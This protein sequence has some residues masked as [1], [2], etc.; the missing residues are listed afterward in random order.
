MGIHDDPTRQDTWNIGVNIEDAQGVMQSWGLW[1]KKTGGELDSDST[2]Y[3]PGGM[4]AQIDLGGRKTAGN[5]TLQKLYDI[6]YDHERIGQLLERVGRAKVNVHQ[7]P[8][9]IDGNPAVKA[10]NWNGRLK[11]VSLPDVDSE[12]STAALVEIEVTIKGY[13]T[14]I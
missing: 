10:V 14:L 3:Y 7:R 12:S 4:R 11:R 8:L 6:V 1:D 13:P 2:T 9:D 5:L